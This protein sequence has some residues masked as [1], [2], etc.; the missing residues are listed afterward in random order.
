[1]NVHHLATITAMKMLLASTLLD[2]L[3]VNAKMDSMVMNKIALMSMSVQSAML[4]I[5]PL[6]HV[7]IHLV[8]STANVMM[9]IRK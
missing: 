5:L 1:M 3:N 7:S 8:N 4:A 2:H 6:P 9:D